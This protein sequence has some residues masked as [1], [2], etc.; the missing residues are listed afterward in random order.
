MPQVPLAHRVRSE[1]RVQQAPRE[2]KV[3]K[4]TPVLQVLPEQQVP[5]GRKGQPGQRVQQGPLGHKEPP[6]PTIGW[7]DRAQRQHQ[8]G[9]CDRGERRFLHQHCCQYALRAKDRWQ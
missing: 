9:C 7:Q 3:H 5:Q 6:A 4:A 8:P 2:C 1:Q